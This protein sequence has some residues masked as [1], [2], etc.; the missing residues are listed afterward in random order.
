M[1]TVIAT[2]IALVTI[3]AL[4]SADGWKK[5][6]GKRVPALE[7]SDWLNVEGETPTLESLKGKVWLLEF[8][9]TW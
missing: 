1:R 7:A 2:A 4:A 9:A 8:F 5:L 6:D 3:G